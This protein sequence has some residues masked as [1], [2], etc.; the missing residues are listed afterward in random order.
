MIRR[1]LTVIALLALALAP[2][3]CAAVAWLAAVTTPPKT[4]P[5][6][7][8]LP[9]ES[10]VLVLVYDPKGLTAD[11]YVRREMTTE[12]NQLLCKHEVAGKTI[13]V[14]LIMQTASVTPGFYRKPPEELGERMGADHVI[15]VTITEFQLKDDPIGHVWKGKLEADVNVYS[16][17]EG[18][19]WPTDRANGYPVPPAT[20]P[21]TENF[22]SDYAQ[23]LANR[24]AREMAAHVAELFY[25]H[26]GREHHEL[27]DQPGSAMPG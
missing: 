15:T 2:A 11:V 3:G 8:E 22:S 21:T 12:L 9:K 7:Y 25:S 4:I 24:L 27:P 10:T 18:L 26:P 17:M 5:A 6:L 20:T 14:K 19:L 13:P 16:T 23:T 1:G